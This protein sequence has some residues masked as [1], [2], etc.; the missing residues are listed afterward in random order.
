M[1][2]SV[3]RL[4]HIAVIRLRTGHAIWY[5]RAAGAAKEGHFLWNFTLESHDG[6]SGADVVLGS[7]LIFRVKAPLSDDTQGRICFHNAIEAFFYVT[8]AAADSQFCPFS[9]KWS[10]IVCQVY[11]VQILLFNEAASAYLCS[12]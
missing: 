10:Q 5:D 1:G 2:A 12:S 7:C 3:S 9:F 4:A 6:T 11:L 8:F